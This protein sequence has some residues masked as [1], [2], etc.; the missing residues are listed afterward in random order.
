MMINRCKGLTLVE[1]MIAL[2]LSMLLMAGTVSIFMASKETLLLEDDLSRIQENFRYIADR[3]T[4]DLSLVGY[5]G[6]SL[7]YDDNSST[8]SNRLSG[9]SGVRNV[10]EGNDGTSSPDK[11][12]LTYAMP[13]TGT[14]V[15]TGKGSDVTAPL[16]ISTAT[17]LYSAL[18]ANLAEDEAGQ[19]PIS[20]LVGNCDGGDIFTVTGIAEHN[21]E[22][23]DSPDV[24][25]AALEHKKDVTVGGLSNA[26]DGFNVTYGD[27][28]LSEAKIFYTE[29]VIY[30]I[31]TDASGNEGLCVTRGSGTR[32]M[33]M[34]D[35][36]DF[37]VKYGLDSSATEDGN[38]DRYVDWSDSISNPDITAIKVT[39]AMALSQVGGQDVTKTYSFT[40]KL[41]NMGLDL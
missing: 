17:R 30:E 8:V 33:L 40:V 35:V 22:D 11:L 18:K 26:E 38:A 29:D 12:T 39:L 9:T 14:T 4:K 25:E 2:L 36:T 23:G 20:L 34:T 37:Q 24:G 1:L 41:R 31:C 5:T 19:V 10:I 21:A 13:G 32:E 7:P 27:E 15:L 16:Y 6:C 28:T 3:L